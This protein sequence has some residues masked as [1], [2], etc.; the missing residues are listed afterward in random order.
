MPASA[1]ASIAV[2]IA[3]L[4]REPGRHERVAAL[5]RA[6][7]VGEGLGRQVVRHHARSCPPARRA[8]RTARRRSSLGTTKRSTRV[9][10]A[11][12]VPRERGGV[13]G[14]LG[15]RAAAV[16]EQPGQRVAVMAAKAG[17][18][19]ARGH[20]DRA[21]EAQVVELHD[22]ASRP[23][24]RAA[25]QGARARQRQHVVHVHHVGAR[26]RGRRPPRRPRRGRRAAARA[27]PPGARRRRSGA[28]AARA[29][30][31]RGA[32]RRAA[33]RRSAPRLPR[34]GSGCVPRGRACGGATLSSRWTRRP[35]A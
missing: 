6:A 20:A 14:R 25:S 19:V 17:A 3:L 32:G 10:H 34:S 28:P 13:D 5:G 8:A 4:R 21:E 16:Q 7:V 33:A 11:R 23:A 24:P 29:P 12:L 9:E 26:A 31:R 2:S 18:A 1:A 15:Q 35:C 27:R 30:R 22:D